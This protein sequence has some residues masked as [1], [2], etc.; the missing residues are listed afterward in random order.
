MTLIAKLP[1]LLCDITANRRPPSRVTYVLSCFLAL[2]LE[3][4]I[5]LVV[6][7]A[8]RSVN[9]QTGSF[10]FSA[11]RA[12]LK[13]H[14]FQR[15]PRERTSGTEAALRSRAGDCFQRPRRA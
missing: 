1:D 2:T 14:R 4:R 5:R 7:P 10:Q 12:P 3:N 6:G 15:A 13:S 11:A 8:R 9:V